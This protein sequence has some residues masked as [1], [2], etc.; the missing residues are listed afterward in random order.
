ML[1]LFSVADASVV[2]AVISALSAMYI[3]TRSR[4]EIKQINTAVN[5]QGPNEPT[6]IERVK[7]IEN[8]NASHTLWEIKVFNA[9]AKQL[10]IEVPQPP[11]HVQDILKENL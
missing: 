6:L 9:I 7:R 4:K 1:A 8:Q 5:H 2:V 10:G 11:E 3:A